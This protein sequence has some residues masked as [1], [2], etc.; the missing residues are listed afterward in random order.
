MNWT[1]LVS[2]VSEDTGMPAKTVREVLDAFVE[3]TLDAVASGED[4]RIK[5]VGTISRRW[6]K[7]TV[8]RSINDH[9]KMMLDGRWTPRFR[10][11]TELKDR[12]AE[13]TPQ[14]WKDSRHQAAWNLAEALVGDLLLYHAELAPTCPETVQPDRLERQ[15]A[16]A[17][18]PLWDRVVQTFRRDVPE[19][20][21]DGRNYLGLVARRHLAA[22]V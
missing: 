4:V 9:R 7:P 2:K 21:R 19:D 6:R 3:N 18:G 1:E 22:T 17:F 13:L 10:P 8:V 16:E 20:V 11:G 14:D 12:L 15:C 5:R